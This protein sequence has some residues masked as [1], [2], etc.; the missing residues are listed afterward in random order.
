MEWPMKR[1]GAA[2]PQGPG[3]RFSQ[4]LRKMPGARTIKRPEIAKTLFQAACPG[5]AA[6]HQTRAASENSAMTRKDLENPFR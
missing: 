2:A 4:Q 5:F 1:T 6:S 3:S